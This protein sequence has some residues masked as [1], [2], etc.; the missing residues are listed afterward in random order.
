MIAF[1][2]RLQRWTLFLAK[3][4]RV[5]GN[6]IIGVIQI[7]YSKCKVH[8]MF[9]CRD[10]ST[11]ICV[12][13]QMGW[14]S[15]DSRWANS[16]HPGTHESLGHEAFHHLV[17][18][19]HRRQG[20]DV[21]AWPVNIYQYSLAH[22]PISSLDCS[23]VK[24]DSMVVKAEWANRLLRSWWEKCKTRVKTRIRVCGSS[25][26]YSYYSLTILDIDR[27]TASYCESMKLISCNLCASKE[28]WFCHS[29][30]SLQRFW[31]RSAAPKAGRCDLRLGD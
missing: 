3:P 16:F 25:I 6:H 17:Q 23:T 28:H 31:C 19:G 21:D 18:A 26:Y 15:A 14:S 8:V 22:P 13:L 30:S 11:A 5:H 10:F 2:Q 20:W 27:S 9:S 1:R 29:A 4:L 24:G 12:S 7:C